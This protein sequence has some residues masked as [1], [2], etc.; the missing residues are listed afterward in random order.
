MATLFSLADLGVPPGS[1][2]H[3]LVERCPKVK[4]LCFDDGEC[5][6]SAGDAARTVYLVLRGG[7]TVETAGGNGTPSEAT[8][9]ATH[10]DTGALSPSFIGEM[11]YLGG[12]RR[13]ATVRSRGAIHALA[14]EPEDLDALIAEFPIFTRILCRQ[15]ADRL[16]EMNTALQEK[17]HLFT[18]RAA[19]QTRENGETVLEKGMD[20][21]HLHQVIEGR[22]SKEVNGEWLPLGPKDAYLGFLF[23]WVYFRDGHYGEHVRADGPVKIRL[24]SQADKLAIIR[25]HPQLMLWCL[26]GH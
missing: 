7:Y 20:A 14:L 23:P 26:N 5:V 2:F 16:R 4:P 11:A 25:N 6:I 8:V 1:E 3:R 24:L 22:V 21:V 12:G 19:V 13:S 17:D 18:L 15:F 9:L 10:E